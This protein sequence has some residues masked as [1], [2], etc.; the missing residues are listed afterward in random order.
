MDKLAKQQTGLTVTAPL[1]SQDLVLGKMLDL[2]AQLM[3]REVIPGEIRL[4]SETFKGTNPATLELAFRDYLK[5]AKF[6]PKPGDITERIEFVREKMRSET[7]ELDNNQRLAEIEQARKEGK[8][9]DP[10]EVDQILHNFAKKMAMEAPRKLKREEGQCK[11]HY[12][13]LSP[14]EWQARKELALL[15]VSRM[16]IV[17][18]PEDHIPLELRVESRRKQA[19]STS[20]VP[21]SS[22]NS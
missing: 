14:G 13:P 9:I 18:K 7:D 17:V 6:F 1:S 22:G 4:W 15:Q 11:A 21:D 19:P 8:L 3:A 2:S 5:T 20:V 12:Q 10:A 16:G